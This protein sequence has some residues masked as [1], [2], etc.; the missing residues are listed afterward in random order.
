MSTFVYNDGSFESK[1]KDTLSVTFGLFFDGTTNNRYH[2]E[3]RKKVEKKG[4][5]K[6]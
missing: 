5:L 1:N 6:P 3:I 2:T 4:S